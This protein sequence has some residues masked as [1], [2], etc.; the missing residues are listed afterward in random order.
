[1]PARSRSGTSCSSAAAPMRRWARTRISRCRRWSAFPSA[2]CCR[3][4][5]RRHHR[6]ADLA[7]VRPLF[8]HGDDRGRRDW[9]RLIVTNTDMSRRGRRPERPD[10]AAQRVR[11]LLR[12]GAAVLLSC[13][14]PCS[15][16]RCC[17]TWWM[18]TSRMGF[19][20]RAIKD[21]ERA[22]RSL[23]APAAPHQALCL[24]AERRSHRRRRRALRH[25]VRLRR[26]GVRARHPDLGEDPDHG[27]ARRRRPA[28]RTAGGRRDPGAA[29]GNLQQPARRQGRGA[30][31]RGLWRDHRADRAL[32][33][34]RPA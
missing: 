25:D 26:S 23:G 29:G 11:S 10:R 17:I 31:L 15:R 30:H 20:L 3:G 18:T 6:R 12:L 33:A 21:S 16:S 7:A 13:S 9:S 22:A 5:D 14:W 4:C 27:R 34:G 32:P 28:V 19:Y 1:M 8:Q 24:H 2:S